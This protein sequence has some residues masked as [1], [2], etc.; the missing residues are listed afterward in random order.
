MTFW[1]SNSNEN[2]GELL[3]LTKNTAENPAAAKDFSTSWWKKLLPAKVLKAADV[4]ANAS[5]EC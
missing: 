3:Q 2:P 4:P 5:Q 1:M